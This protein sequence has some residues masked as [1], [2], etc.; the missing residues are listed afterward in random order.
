MYWSIRRELWEN[1][2]LYI[3]PLAAAAVFL[4]GF[5]IKMVALRRQIYGS[6]L[7]PAQ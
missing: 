4:L 7:D 6:P 1:R 3:G 5:V 2:S